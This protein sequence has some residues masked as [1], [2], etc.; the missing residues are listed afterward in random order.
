MGN[1]IFV[2]GITVTLMGIGIVFS[3][4]L[5]ISFILALFEIVFKEKKPVASDVAVEP[6]KAE[7]QQPVIEQ[8]SVNEIDDKELV[9]VI[10]AAI[11]ASMNTTTDG[12]IVRSLR[13]V[14]TWNKEAI[15]EQQ[16]IF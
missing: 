6:L 3:I 5:I 13:R 14:N 4:L 9:A 16:N 2:E 11:A 8:E 15:Q 7:V 1:E 10:T 12:L